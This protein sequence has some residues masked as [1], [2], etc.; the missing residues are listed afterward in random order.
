MSASTRAMSTKSSVSWAALAA[1]IRRACSSSGI[2]SRLDSPVVEAVALREQV[3]LDA[4]GGDA[5]ALVLHDGADEVREPAEAV[6]AVGDDRQVGRAVAPD[7]PPSSVSV[8]V[9]RFRSG[10]AWAIVA[11]PKPLTHTASKP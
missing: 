10:R 2:S 7:A 6:V 5:G 8:I 3:V 1:R 11:T 9:V 4:D